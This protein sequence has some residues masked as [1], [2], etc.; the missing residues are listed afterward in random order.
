MITDIYFFSLTYDTISPH[1]ILRQDEWFELLCTL[2]CISKWGQ[3]WQYLSPK[4]S[5]SHNII[6]QNKITGDW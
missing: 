2:S 4:F 5:C 3:T 6:D 1:T